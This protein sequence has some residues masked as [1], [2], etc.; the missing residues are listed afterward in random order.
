MG[1]ERGGDILQDSNCLCAIAEILIRLDRIEEAVSTYRQAL[2]ID[3]Q[4][5]A[6]RD[7]LKQALEKM[8]KSDSAK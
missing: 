2:E 1:Q 5:A 7:G 4:N 6:A 8:S 3:P